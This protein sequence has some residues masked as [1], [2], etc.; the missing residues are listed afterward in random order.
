MIPKLRCRRLLQNISSTPLLERDLVKTGVIY[1]QRVRGE[2]RLSMRLRNWK[3]HIR[4]F[5]KARPTQDRS[6]RDAPLIAIDSLPTTAV[7]C[8]TPQNRTARGLKR[9]ESLPKTCL[10][11]RFLK[12]RN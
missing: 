7:T 10:R 12:K 1:L 8:R 5:C 9:F 3:L 2:L 11:S 6:I 4:I